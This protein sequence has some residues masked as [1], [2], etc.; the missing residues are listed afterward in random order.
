MMPPSISNLALV[1]GLWIAL[2]AG[3]CN[4]FDRKMDHGNSN[5][6][7]HGNSNSSTPSSSPASTDDNFGPGI[8][9]VELFK[10]YSDDQAA[11]DRKYKNKTI[12]VSGKVRLANSSSV[13]LNSGAQSDILGVQCILADKASKDRAADLKQGQNATVEGR[14]MGRLGN[15]ALVDCKIK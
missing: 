14:C 3:C 7:N 8:S 4:L 9:A 5:N 13:V 11:A 10:E 12:T 15:V 6:M 2:A 1:F